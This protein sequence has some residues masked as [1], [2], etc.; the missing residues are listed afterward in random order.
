M[1]EVDFVTSDGTR[2][3]LY[4]REGYTLM[5]VAVRAGIPGIRAE[6]GGACACAT[7][8]VSVAPEWAERV[9]P[10]HLAEDMLLDSL[11]RT[12]TSRLACQ[13]KLKAALNGLEVSVPE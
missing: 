3:R 7:C 2:E 8:H 13:V 5:E 9:G 11:D 12:P 4:G 10:P 1:I 6:C